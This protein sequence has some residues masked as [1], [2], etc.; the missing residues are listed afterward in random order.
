M[1]LTLTELRQRLFKLA[2]QVIDS[3][4]PLIIER[5]GVRLKLMREDA[6]AS[7]SRLKKLVVRELVVGEPLRPDESPAVWTESHSPRAAEPRAV[8]RT[9]LGESKPRKRKP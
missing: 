8:Y 5:R 2:D 6:P 3:G 9:N 1:N 4:E 7:S